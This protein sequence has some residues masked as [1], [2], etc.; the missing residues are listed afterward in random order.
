MNTTQLA[1]ATTIMAEIALALHPILI[2]QVPVGLPTQLLARLGTYSV[3]AGAAASPKDIASSWGSWPVA[4]K[5]IGFGLMNLVHIGSSYLSYNHLPAGSALALFYTY[6]FF[7]ILA[8]VLF[9]GESF[10][11]AILPLLLAAFVGVLFIAK[12]TKDGDEDSEPTNGTKKNITLGVAASLISALT[13]TMIFMITKTG[14][15]PT[16]WSPILKLYPGALAGLLAWGAWSGAEFQTSFK[17]WTPLLL[18]N[19]FIGFLGYSLRFWSIPRLPTAVFSI[20][21]FIGVA[22]GYGWGLMYAKEVPS[23]GALFGAGLITGALALLGGK[24]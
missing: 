22:A 3:L 6:P 5:S 12:Y 17:N 21:T 18:F 2:K 9:L 7:N 23:K 20:L 1:T 16:A 11:A 10:D 24:N 4:W 19:I 8:G 13:E 14:E 15:E